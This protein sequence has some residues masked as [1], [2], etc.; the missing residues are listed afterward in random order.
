MSVFQ[1]L[2][3]S[4]K[5]ETT[6]ITIKSRGLKDNRQS[7]M[8]QS[9]LFNAAKTIKILLISLVGIPPTLAASSSKVIINQLFIK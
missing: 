6:G 8:R 5:A 9:L 4:C 7:E 1:K 2:F 3:L